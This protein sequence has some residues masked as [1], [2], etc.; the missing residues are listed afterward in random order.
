MQWPEEASRQAVEDFE[1]MLPMAFRRAHTELSEHGEFWP[2]AVVV[3][4]EG[5]QQMA[6]F[7]PDRTRPGG[8]EVLAELRRSLREST[9]PLRAV[10]LV[11]DVYVPSLRSDT[12]EIALEHLGSP[13]RTVQR[14]YTRRRLGGRLS[15]RDDVLTDG[16][17]T[18]LT[19]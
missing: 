9:E 2:F 8:G 11:L 5:H 17:A 14:A 1:R 16:T 3:D 19:R 12:I 10:A 6:A 15:Y 7:E 18:V 4:V 13:A